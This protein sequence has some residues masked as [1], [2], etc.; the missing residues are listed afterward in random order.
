M[1]D[2]HP[3]LDATFLQQM[4]D[5]WRAANCLSVGQMYLRDNP[6]RRRALALSGVKQMLL[7][8]WGTTPGQNFIYMHLNR[9]ITKYDLDMIY[10]CGPVHAKLLAHRAYIVEQGEDIPEIRRWQWGVCA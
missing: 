7:G 5:Y 6:L 2:R 10:I 9:V 3:T 1:I 4:N 8:H